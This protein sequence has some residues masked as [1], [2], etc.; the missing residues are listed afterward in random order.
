M[1]FSK[2]SPRLVWLLMA[3]SG[4]AVVAPPAATARVFSPRVVSEHTAD[5]YSIKSF[6]Q[7]PRWRDLEGDAR[8]RAIFEYLTDRETGVYPLGMGAFEGKDKTYEHSLVRD[9]VKMLNVYSTGFC[10]V[11]GPVMAGLWREAGFGPA[12]TLDIA[13][14]EHVAAEVFYNDRWHYLDLDL[15]AAFLRD[16]GTLASFEDARNDDTLWKSQ[17]APRF[18]PRD[19]VAKLRETYQKSAV[20]YR[21][22][23]HQTGHTM[24]FVLRRG[25]TF[26]RWWKP[27]GGRWAHHES[28]HKTPQFKTLFEAEPRGPKSKHESFTVH[29]YGNGRF[30]YEPNLKAGSADFAD[31]VDEHGNVAP[32]QAGLTLAEAGEGFAVFEIRSPYVIVPVVGD[33]AK[34]DDDKEASVVEIDAVGVTVEISRDN[35]ATW[36]PQAIKTFPA[37]LDL[38]KSVAGTYGYLLKLVVKGKPG[39]AVVKSLKVT[40]W[41][42][43]APASLPAL[44]SGKNRLALRTGDDHG[45]ATRVV[46][47]TPDASVPT[48]LFKVLITPPR[49]YN[50]RSPNSRV[51]GPFIVRVAAIPGTKVAWLTAGGSFRADPQDAAPSARNAIEYAI[52]SPVEFTELFRAEVPAGMNH[53][54][55][56]ASRELRLD[57]PA[58][59]VYLRYTGDP[60]INNIRIYAHCL[61]NEPRPATSLRVTHRWTEE[62]NAKEFTT[63][64]DAAGTYDVDVA[65]EP[66][67]ESIE[68]A[69]PSDASP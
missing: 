42:Q 40:S 46:E 18:F 28:Y 31:G 11:F 37:T 45:L 34:G 51:K 44:R 16:D 62:G 14:F 55:F 67:N 32:G 50:A 69:V 20:N 5:T 53:W 21:Y 25:E 35:G 10:D 52:G 22:G 63:S 9:P 59:Q 49:E 12:R 68:L 38:T 4:V 24:D 30:V 56:N 17:P 13:D 65:G 43:L 26:T 3:V 8:A 27:Q 33:L 23:V 7:F 36:E 29:T 61:E 2:R 60:A 47:I 15:R 66:V 48:D 41:V 57:A 54:H 64:L 58:E 1:C 39:E 6:A 19:N